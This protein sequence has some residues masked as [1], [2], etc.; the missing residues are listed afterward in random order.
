LQKEHL[1]IRRVI[2]FDSKQKKKKKTTTETSALAFVAFSLW[3]SRC[4][5]A[6]V[7]IVGV[8]CGS[9]HHGILGV[10]GEELW[11]ECNTPAASVT[12]LLA[13]V[14]TYRGMVSC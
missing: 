9:A 2:K 13:L 7:M 6:L 14:H 11:R 3:W 12:L 4:P 1:S 5:Y 10:L 8:D